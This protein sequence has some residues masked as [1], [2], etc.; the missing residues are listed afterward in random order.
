MKKRKQQQYMRET[1][2]KR[3]VNCER[4]NLG[5]KSQNNL[6]TEIRI[7][8]KH[9]RNNLVYHPPPPSPPTLPR[10]PLHL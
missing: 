9:L 5:H 4:M 3:G 7:A 6:L 8:F 10:R 2:S 1:Q